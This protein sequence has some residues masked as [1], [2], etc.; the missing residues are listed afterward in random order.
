MAPTGAATAVATAG[1]PAL[2]PCGD[3]APALLPGSLPLHK[4]RVSSISYLLSVEHTERA[5]LPGIYQVYIIPA[6]ELY[7]I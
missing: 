6:L 1:L 4:L 5:L 7:S 2:C 3:D